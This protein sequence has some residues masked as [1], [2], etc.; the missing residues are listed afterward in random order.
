MV[1]EFEE[2]GPRHLAGK[3]EPDEMGLLRSLWCPAYDGCLEVAF[4]R[5]WT[6]WSCEGC[7]GFRQAAPLRK[8]A[9]LHSFCARQ[10]DLPARAIL[11]SSRR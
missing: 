3:R 8:Q 5:G 4:R 1:R 6:S 11:P 7:V 9:A 10:G 2:A